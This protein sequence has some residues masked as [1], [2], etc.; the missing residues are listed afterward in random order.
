MN[1]A[2]LL[3]AL[4]SPQVIARHIIRSFSLG[5]L[6]FRLAMQ[7]LEKGEYAFGIKQAVYLASRLEHSRISVLEFGVGTGNGLKTMERYAAELG[8]K[9]GVEVD[10]YGFDLGSGLPAPSDYR[11]LPYIWKA[12]DYQMDARILQTQLKG[13]KLLLGDVRETIPRFMHT[14]PAPIG[15]ISFDLDYYSSTSAAFRLFDGA[16]DQF[17]PRVICYFDDLSSDGRA[18][19]SEYVGELLAIRKFNESSG[20]R[21][22]L[23]PFPIQEHLVKYP[24]AWHQMMWVYHRFFHPEYNTYVRA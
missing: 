6:E 23:C 24:A 10:V 11:D 15:F 20:E 19:H 14:K 8:G 1:S 21:H 17:L 2:M 9:Y 7:A 12:G 13:A 22:K 4:L 5:S 3:R 16:D 18:L